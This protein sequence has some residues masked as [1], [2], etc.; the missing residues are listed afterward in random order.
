MV[1]LLEESER[2]NTERLDKLTD[3][4]VTVSR[5]INEGFSLLRDL[6]SQPQLQFA[7]PHGSYTHMQRPPP[8]FMHTPQHSAAL[9]IMHTP[10]HS[11]HA[12]SPYTQN[13]IHPQ[14]PP[15]YSY[16][17]SLLQDDTE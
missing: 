14:T 8:G 7:H 6:M 1:E 12:P 16:M 4:I 10:Q 15:V 11:S 17:Q 13:P 5:T 2:H 9:G 3:N